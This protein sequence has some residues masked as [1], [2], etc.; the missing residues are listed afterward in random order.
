MIRFTCGKCSTKYGFKEVCVKNLWKGIAA[1]WGVVG[2]ISL[3]ME[4]A[5]GNLIIGLAIVRF[6]AH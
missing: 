1:M 6:S 2:G 3:E 5:S 4:Q